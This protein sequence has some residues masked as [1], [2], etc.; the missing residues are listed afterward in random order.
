[1]IKDLPGARPL[2]AVV[3]LRPT[4]LLLHQRILPDLMVGEFIIREDGN[5]V[6]DTVPGVDEGVV[7][8]RRHPRHIRRPDGEDTPLIRS[9]IYD[10][11]RGFTFK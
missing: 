7:E 9:R 5:Q 8:A 3:R 4:P 6:E 11:V 2:R 10:P 1:M